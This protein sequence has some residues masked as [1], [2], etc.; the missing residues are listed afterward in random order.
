M[1]TIAFRLS[2]KD[3]RALQALAKRRAKNKGQKKV[4]NASLVAGSQMYYYCRSCGE[5]MALPEAHTCPV[6]LF[7]NACDGLRTKGLLKKGVVSK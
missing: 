7:C 6:P 5:E 4:D 3:K 2:Q 1:P